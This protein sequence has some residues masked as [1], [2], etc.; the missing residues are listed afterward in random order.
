MFVSLVFHVES[1]AYDDKNIN[2]GTH[3]RLKL[4]RQSR[5]TTGAQGPVACGGLLFGQQRRLEALQ[6]L[7]AQRGATSTSAATPTSRQGTLSRRWQSRRPWRAVTLTLLTLAVMAGGAGLLLTHRQPDPVKIPDPL[8]IQLAAG[9]F[10]CPQTPSWAPDALHVAVVISDDTCPEGGSPGHHSI[11]I[12]DT[13]TGKLTQRLDLDGT[14][15]KAGL[16]EL[17]T[18]SGGLLTWSPNG[19]SIAVTT[20]LPAGPTTA[21]LGVLVF[22][23]AGQASRLLT[24]RVPYLL[25]QETIN[26]AVWDHDRHHL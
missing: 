17:S 18:G 19:E 13:Q 12:Y 22:S 4:K 23:L 2:T 5:L 24:S 15:T 26:S 8:I 20:L 14:L 21:N 25:N 10:Y 7:V 6:Q 1:I 11:A 16:P 9:K 3:S